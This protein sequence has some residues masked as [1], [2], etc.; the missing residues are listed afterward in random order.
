MFILICTFHDL[1]QE[2]YSEIKF[3]AGGSAC[4]VARCLSS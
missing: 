4:E 2:D 1:S 3:L